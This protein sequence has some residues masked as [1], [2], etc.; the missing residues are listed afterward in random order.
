VKPKKW[1]IIE[2]KNI[3][4]IFLI[5]YGKDKTELLNN[6]ICA[7]TSIIVN[8]SSIKNFKQQIFLEIKANDFSNQIFSLIEKLIYFKDVEGLVFKKGEFS[9]KKNVLYAQL[10]GAKINHEQTK[11]DIKALAKHRFNLK[12][13]KGIYQLSLVFDI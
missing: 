2:D 5:I 11:I 10:F 12:K 7:F 6:V 4:D 9:F 8:I 13:K 3:A 1:E